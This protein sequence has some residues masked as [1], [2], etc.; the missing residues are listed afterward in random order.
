M[1]EAA[2]PTNE[3]CGPGAPYAVGAGRGTAR[4]TGP[5][6]LVNARRGSLPCRGDVAFVTSW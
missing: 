4:V 5:D 6:A 2:F 3:R 1:T